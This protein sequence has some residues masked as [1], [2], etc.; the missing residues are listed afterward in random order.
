MV[1][2]ILNLKLLAEQERLFFGFFSFTEIRDNLDMYI[3]SMKILFKNAKIYHNFQR[4]HC[5]INTK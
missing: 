2:D 1:S 4:Y 5:Y 3:I